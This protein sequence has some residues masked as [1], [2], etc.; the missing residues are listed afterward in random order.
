MIAIFPLS[1]YGNAQKSIDKY[2]AAIYCRKKYSHKGKW[3]YLFV[4]NR[5][6]LLLSFYHLLC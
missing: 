5:Q 3:D 2:G 4:L 6:I 1:S